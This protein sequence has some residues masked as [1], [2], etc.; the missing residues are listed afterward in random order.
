MKSKPCSGNPITPSLLLKGIWLVRA[1]FTI[2]TPVSVTVEDGR[3]S[4][5]RD[6]CR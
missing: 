1:G 6:R 3:L 4:I 2:D 5:V